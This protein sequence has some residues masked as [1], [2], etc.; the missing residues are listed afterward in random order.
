MTKIWHAEHLNDEWE[1]DADVIWDLAVKLDVSYRHVE[2]LL[3]NDKLNAWMNDDLTHEEN[4]NVIL[5]E[6]QRILAKQLLSQHGD[7]IYKALLIK[8]G[9]K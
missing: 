5:T 6:D 3:G 2:V 8:K 7:T 4:L 1:Y 9:M